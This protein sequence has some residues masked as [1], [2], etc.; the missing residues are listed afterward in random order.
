[1]A[2]VVMQFGQE[3]ESYVSLGA[4][5][6]CGMAVVYSGL[7]TMMQL[8]ICFNL[9]ISMGYTRSRFF[10]LKE[11]SPFREPLKLKMPAG[12]GHDE[13]DGG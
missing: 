8:G 2:N 6:G 5:M 13:T 9:E 1:M 10:V 7:W 11:S 3:A 12:S 4:I